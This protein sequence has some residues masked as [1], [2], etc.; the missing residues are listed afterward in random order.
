MSAQARSVVVKL[1]MESSQLIAG[2]KAAE[3]AVVSGTKGM[4]RATMSQARAV[5]NLGNKAGMIGAG[6][7]LALGASAKAAMDWES[8]FAGV[9][10]TVDGTVEQ[11]SQLEGEL[12]NLAKTMPATH[13]EIAG[14]AEAAG[15]LGVARE[16]IADF[17]DTMIQLGEATGGL[18]TAEQA[19][20]DIA[21]I[22]NVMGTS[23][24]EVDNFGSALVALGNDG[25]STEAQILSMAQRIAGA[26]AQIG[27]AESDILAIANAAA[28]MGIE[29]EAGGSAIS[30]VFTDMAKA[31]KQGGA[32]LE[33]FAG[34]AGMS[35]SEFVRAFGE[36]PAQAFAAFTAGLNEINASG[37]D[38]FTT[39]DGLGLSDVRVSQ[40]LLGMAA[41]GD[42][43]T[44]SLALGADA[45]SENSALAD[46]FAKRMD[47]T[48]ADV[49]KA[50]NNVRDAGIDAGAALLPVLSEVSDKVSTVAQAFGSLPDPVQG[51]VT[52]MLALTAITGGGLW[53]GAKVI[54]AVT[55]TR[56]AIKG[57]GTESG[58][59]G[60]KLR[61]LSI[62]TT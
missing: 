61:A 45:W 5:E 34:V 11:I 43:L 26:G 15:Q 9:E 31:T 56:E 47:T 44:D 10:K 7:A 52:K 28:S 37:G 54:G 21:Q 57:L 17:T 40:A 38:V 27:L 49:Q 18:L 55:D 12:R 4:E 8:Q 41:S 3:A 19:A 25:A 50:W 59:A 13:E 14:V 1:S 6:A 33:Q 20:T 16:D 53:F 29:A 46:E 42:L 62:A 22:A 30:R 58:T 32:D 60:S 35:A 36:D 39:L 51:V 2:M 24:A 48:G 23:T